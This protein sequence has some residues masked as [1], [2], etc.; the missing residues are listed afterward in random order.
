MIPKMCCI[1]KW[2]DKR[3]YSYML[4]QGPDYAV[5]KLLNKNSNKYKINGLKKRQ[6]QQRVQIRC[7]KNSKSLQIF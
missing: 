2:M 3:K 6:K 7:Y 1:I 5:P 4:D